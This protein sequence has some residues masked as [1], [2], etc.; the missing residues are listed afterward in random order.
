MLVDVEGSVQTYTVITR[1]RVNGEVITHFVEHEVL[2][3]D[4]D[5]VSDE[6]IL[7]YGQYGSTWEGGRSSACTDA[8]ERCQ[9]QLSTVRGE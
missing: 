8:G 4:F 7:W 9:G 2:D 6:M 5:A 1:W 3:R